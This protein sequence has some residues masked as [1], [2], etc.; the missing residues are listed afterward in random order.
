M[1]LLKDIFGYSANECHCRIGPLSSLDVSGLD[2]E[3][4]WEVLQTRNRPLSRYVKKQL[5]SLTITALNP[6]RK[7]KV[8]SDQSRE[9]LSSKKNRNVMD[10]T[11]EDMTND[12]T[13]EENEERANGLP[14]MAD[15]QS[16]IS[17]EMVEMD[18]ADE[19]D[20]EEEREIAL[21]ELEEAEAKHLEKMETKSKGSGHKGVNEVIRL[22]CI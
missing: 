11:D 12:H 2:T 7:K 22:I 3:S 5:R 18:G 16:N 9:N 17:E 10:D 1:R 13:E 14:S 8:L 15:E 21:D 6:S 19:L 20:D 4:I